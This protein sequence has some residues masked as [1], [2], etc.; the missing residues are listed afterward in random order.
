ML[1]ALPIA[2]ALVCAGFERG[3]RGLKPGWRYRL[4]WLSSPEAS[5]LVL[6][7]AGA[8]VMTLSLV[9]T[10][11]RSGIS[12]AAVSLLLTGWFIVRGVRGRSRKAAGAAY[13]LLLAITVV[14]WIGADTIVSRFAKA[15]W[16]EFNNRRGAW[17]D[18]WN[19]AT[20]FPLTGAGLN[21][22]DTLATYYQ[23]HDLK[24]RFGEAHNDYLQLAAEGGLLVG[25]PIVI[26]L[27]LFVREMWR[28]MKDEPGSTSWWLRRGA[29]T[30]LVAIALQETVDFS[31]QMPGNAALF[32]VICAIAIHR[33]Q[34]RRH[35]GPDVRS[36]Q[37]PS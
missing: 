5:R 19:V 9:L 8:A 13:L 12:A 33:P 28:Q 18:A 10:M 11:S 31:L 30:A 6:L 2:L 1:M 16:S 26:C 27:L 20:E 17:T 3:M 37:R 34:P 32:A 23:R 7:S 4:L 21:T 14:G 15:D 29:I 35:P 24:S 25:L 36:P 22:Y